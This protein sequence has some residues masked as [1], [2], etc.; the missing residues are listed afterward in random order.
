MAWAYSKA[1]EA[2]KPLVAL[3]QQ[4]TVPLAAK[5]SAMET[6]LRS[7]P[8]TP[9]MVEQPLPGRPRTKHISPG[10]TTPVISLTIFFSG[11]PWFF[12][13]MD[14]IASKG[15]MTRSLTVGA[16]ENSESTPHVVTFSITTPVERKWIP[17]EDAD[18]KKEVRIL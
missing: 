13:P 11:V 17:W 18:F 7:P 8:E 12:L 6:L 5:A 2:S 10:L 15:P 1:V 3:S 4:Y 16:Y 9:R 14:L